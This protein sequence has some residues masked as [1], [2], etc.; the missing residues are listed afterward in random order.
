MR[1]PRRSLPPL[2]FLYR[3]KLGMTASLPHGQSKHVAIFASPRAGSGAGREEI[4]RLIEQ[5]REDGFEVRTCESAR[6]LQHWCGERGCEQDQPRATIVAAGGD[7]TIT[8]AASVVLEIANPIDHETNRQTANPQS[9]CLLPMPLGTENLLAKHF[10]H[11]ATAAGV[12]NTIQNGKRTSLDMG[13]VRRIT[14]PASSRR[15][16]AAKPMLT[17]VSCGFDADVVRQVHLKRKG[18]IRRLNYFAPILHAMRSYHF[19]ELTVELLGTSGRVDRKIQGGW[20]M[21]FNL[22]RYAGG[23]KI[24]PDAIGDDGWLDVIVFR[25]RSWLKGL[26]YFARIQT[27]SHLQHPDI[28]RVQAKRIQITSDQRVHYQIDG[29]YIGQLPIEITTRPQAIDVLVP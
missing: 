22:P 12:R 7:G 4:P 6:Q 25:G 18:H 13:M 28:T 24:E 10:G 29:D 20:A 3:S 1:L 9:P 21:V 2:F 16:V 8:L 11:L 27:G 15:A 19:P 14:D 23:L 5:L 26:N 17:M